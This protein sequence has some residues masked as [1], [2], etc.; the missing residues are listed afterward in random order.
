MTEQETIIREHAEKLLK[1][2]KKLTK[3]HSDGEVALIT[4]HGPVFIWQ[5]HA[6]QT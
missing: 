2:L 4:E 5:M 1:Q 3:A 6:L